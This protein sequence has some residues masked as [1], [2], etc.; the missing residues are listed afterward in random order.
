MSCTWLIPKLTANDAP[1]IRESHSTVVIPSIFVIK[2]HEGASA[3]LSDWIKITN[4]QYYNEI[5]ELLKKETYAR[6]LNGIEA[7]QIEYTLSLMESDFKQG[8]LP[9]WVE[10]I[11]VICRDAE[12]IVSFFARNGGWVETNTGA[13]ALNKNPAYI[14]TIDPKTE[15]ITS[16]V[17]KLEAIIYANLYQSSIDDGILTDYTQQS[18]FTAPLNI[19]KISPSEK[20][21]VGRA[22]P[23]KTSEVNRPSQP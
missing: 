19:S 6:K 14:C 22:E 1:L 21:E 15:K 17:T 9:R 18:G 12:V 20:K 3:R 13:L 7:D 11:F 23:T 2:D 5:F 4:K 8:I 10:N 16:D